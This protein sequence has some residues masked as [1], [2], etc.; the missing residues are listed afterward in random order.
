MWAHEEND[1]V[2]FY[3]VLQL[4][5]SLYFNFLLDYIFQ[6]PVFFF[7]FFLFRNT[8]HDISLFSEP[9][10]RETSLYYFIPGGR[11]GAIYKI[12]SSWNSFHKIQCGMEY[13]KGIILISL[14]TLLKL[15]TTWNEQ[16]IT[17]E[18][19]LWRG[20][21]RI[22]EYIL[23]CYRTE[24]SYKLRVRTK[25]HIVNSTNPNN[26]IALRLQLHIF[27]VVGNCYSV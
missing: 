11:T 9:S 8:S 13:I 22:N 25:P 3:H 16:K 14:P 19:R 15:F 12:S 23:N 10:L 5:V 18:E 17:S 4:N 26:K 7:Y 27:C 20:A 1:N 21:Y 2:L 6:T 24:L